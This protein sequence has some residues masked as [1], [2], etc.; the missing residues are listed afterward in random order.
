LKKTLRL[1]L[2]ASRKRGHL[3]E[4][5]IFYGGPGLGKT[6]LA[7]IIAS[8]QGTRL[9]ELAAPSI[10]R[11]GELA[12]VL[13]VLQKG[14][15]LFLD[16]I[17]ALKRES[18]ELLYGAMEDFKVSI[19]PE[20]SDRPITLALYP[21]T[22][23]GATTDFGL[24]PDPMRSRFGQSFYLQ[25]YTLEELRQVVLRASDALGFLM[26]EEAL[27]GIAKRSRGTPRVALRLF[28]RCVDAAT[29][30]DLFIIDSELVE[31]TMP[32][33]GLDTLGLEDADRKYLAALVAVY[34]GGPTGPR[35]IAS[36]AGLDL[37]TVEHVVEPALLT[38]GLIARTPRGRRVTRSG[39]EHIKTF[40]P[41]PEIVNWR[42]VED[43]DAALTTNNDGNEE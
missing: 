25:P 18:S 17:H 28:R 31:S 9:H 26:D 32:I 24:L 39:Y 7:G 23:V 19:K 14:D 11:P 21:F 30:T 27:T 5:V 12:Q 33:L 22:L 41:T 20:Q 35:S 10:T 2:D 8:E 4:H 40:T 16:E 1:M 29:N 6:T 34:K 3:L 15:V 13:T 36:S 37:A 42:K 38:A 43:L